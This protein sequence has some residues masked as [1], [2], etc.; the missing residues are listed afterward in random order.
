M[1][2]QQAR[3]TTSWRAFQVSVRCWRESCCSHLLLE[4]LG[5]AGLRS[6]V[7]SGPRRYFF[8][9]RRQLQELA[10]QGRNQRKISAGAEVTF[11]HDYVIDVQSTMMRPFCYDQLTKKMM[12]N[13]ENRKLLHDY[14]QSHILFHQ[15]FFVNILEIVFLKFSV[16]KPRNQSILD[17]SQYMKSTE[18]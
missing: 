5:K 1:A 14:Y 16:V 18:E 4:N 17:I 13:S 10:T 12:I 11:G 8:M 15:K 9:C 7:R 2:S 3:R 6:A